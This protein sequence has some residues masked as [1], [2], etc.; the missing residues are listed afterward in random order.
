MGANYL[1]IVRWDAK[2]LD[3]KTAAARIQK[4]LWAPD[5]SPLMAFENGMVFGYS[6]EEQPL[7]VM[8]A[9]AK[10]LDLKVGQSQVLIARV[11]RP[12]IGAPAPESYRWLH[13]HLPQL[14]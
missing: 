14:S 4:V 7:T 12:W 8:R 13:E 2:S 1:L 6:S 11:D 10:A 5:R 3:L 9:V